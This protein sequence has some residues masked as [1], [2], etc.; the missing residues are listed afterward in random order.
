MN[1]VAILQS[2]YIPWRGYFDI[3]NS[4]DTFVIFDDVQYTK[5]DWR[6]RNLIKTAQGPQ[7]LTV[8]VL[9]H[10]KLEQKICE[11]RI[12]HD[13]D[14]AKKHWRAIEMNYSKT[15]YFNLYREE[16]GKI[17]LECQWDYLSDLNTTLIKFISGLL[18]IKTKFV[19]SQSL[20]IAERESEDLSVKRTLKLIDICKSVDGQF[21]L[22]GPAAKDYIVTSLFDEANIILNYMDYAGYP[23]YPQRHAPFTP[24]V[25]ILDLLF[26]CGPDSPKYIWGEFRNR[27][28]QITS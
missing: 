18:G 9:S 6:N 24:G 3:I 10:E 12:S 2:N 21:Y 22:S 20:G 26:N 5:R 8:P 19:T 13:A 27:V 16:L 14:W 17:W 23:E 4:V 15:K 28:Q 25:T 1:K 7:W 11:A